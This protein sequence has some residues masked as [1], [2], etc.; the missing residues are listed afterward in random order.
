MNDEA[1]QERR[2]ND[3]VPRTLFLVNFKQCSS[4]ETR[5]ITRQSIASLDATT[6]MTRLNDCF[7][8]HEPTIIR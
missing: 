7:S 8:W 6:T 1:A 5:Y 3:L 2:G 4:K